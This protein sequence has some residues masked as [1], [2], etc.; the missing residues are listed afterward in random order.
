M[1][2]WRP[3]TDVVPRGAAEQSAAAALA[4]R[5]PEGAAG[6]LDD[7]RDGRSAAAA[8]LALALEHPEVVRVVADVAAGVDVVGERGAPVLHA[9]GEGRL[10]ALDEAGGLGAG[11]ARALSRRGE[12]GEEAGLG[13]GDVADAGDEALIQQRLLDGP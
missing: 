4:L 10:D 12:A 9:L 5:A 6:A 2:D 13:G 11:E 3:L 8:G 7:A 1:V